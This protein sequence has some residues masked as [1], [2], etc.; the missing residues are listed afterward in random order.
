MKLAQILQREVSDPRL[1]GVHVTRVELGRDLAR[2]RVFW[3]TLPG[4]ATE[5]QARDGFKQAQGHLRRLVAG[6]LN[7]RNVPELV[8]ELDES[9]EQDD[10]MGALLA[11]L[12]PAGGLRAASAAAGAVSGEAVFAEDDSAEDDSAE[13]DE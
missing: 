8:F 12:R 1:A 6:A 11:G 5:E 10:R 3:R 13:D 2:A 4:A 7:L 9:L